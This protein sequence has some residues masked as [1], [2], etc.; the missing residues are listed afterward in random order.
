MGSNCT[1][2]I[3]I[4]V[5]H[6]LKKIN[7]LLEDLQEFEENFEII[8]VDGNPNRETINII[9]NQDIKILVSKEGRGRQMNTGA[10]S[11]G[12]EILIFLHADTQ[13]PVTALDR[14]R[15]ALKKKQYVGGAFDLSIR[16]DKLI[17]KV[18]A[19]CA[20]L[21]SRLTRIPYGDQ[22]IFIRKDYFNKI[23]GYKEI[24]LMED[25]ELMQRIKKRGDKICIL[26]DRVFTS[27][28]RW[29]KEGII[30]CT[31]RNWIIII[32]YLIGISPDKLA[33]YYG[34]N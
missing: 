28:R 11:A 23:G 12:G 2:S 18:I 14:I 19:K 30:C 26:S 32:L 29:E 5:L 17:L 25:V 34:R 22:A 20:S 8:V 24:P 4:P 15:H 31:L 21:R 9:S 10:A 13:L 16:S 7:L 3:I 33:R 6:E 1:F 27:P